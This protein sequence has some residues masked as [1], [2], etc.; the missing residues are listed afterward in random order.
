MK[1]L[2]SFIFVVIIF[3]LAI[4][5]FVFSW[6]LWKNDLNNRIG[7]SFEGEELEC[8]NYSVSYFG[9]KRLIPVVDM[10]DG[11]VMDVEIN[12]K[13]DEDIYVEF[14]LKLKRIASELK[15]DNFK[16]ALVADNKI[17]NDG[18][19]DSARQEETIILASNQLIIRGSNK[20]EFYLWIDNNSKNKF[21]VGNK[22]YEFV[23]SSNIIDRK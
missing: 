4:V 15:K 12:Q 8:M 7:V 1:R 10:N 3:I 9:D 14:N 5:V 2:F 13:C 17:I 16:Y 11:Y 22:N 21:N 19:F 6:F 18:N 20:Y 23:L